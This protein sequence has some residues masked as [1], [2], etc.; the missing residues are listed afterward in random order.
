MRRRSMPLIAAIAAVTAF[1]APAAQQGYQQPPQVI[2]DIMSA[3]PL[4]G[5]SLSPDRS[6]LL[7][8]YRDS[9]P[10]IA[11]VA[12]PWIGLAG[13]RISP[14]TNG[15]HTLNA[16]RALALKDVATGAER[17][18]A[19]PDDGFFSGTF[20]PDGRHVAI[21]HTTGDTI[22]LLVADVATGTVR[23]VLDRGVNGIAGGC[24]WL[25]SS[26]GFFCHLIPQGRGAAPER[27]R[28]PEGP[29]IQENAGRALPGRT[30]QDLLDDAHDARLFDY[31]YASQLAHVGLDG[32]V[33]PIGAPGAYDAVERSHDERYLLVPRLKKPYSYLVPVWQ[34][35]REVELWDRAGTVSPEGMSATLFWVEE[36]GRAHV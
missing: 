8:S 33:T 3:P 34:F 36:I 22:R 30:Y 25:E 35:A 13:L 14:D 16:P 26:D 21:T 7:L 18:L 23:T 5:V 4:P 31:Y 28:V 9:M 32:R 27:P 20:S 2:V 11:E 1:A 24:D 6:T 29:T 17:K 15:P 12:A 19:L 10:S